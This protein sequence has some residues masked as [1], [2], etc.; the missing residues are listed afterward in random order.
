MARAIAGYGQTLESMAAQATED[1]VVVTLR[2]TRIR[3][4]G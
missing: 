2:P 3:A 1:R 4:Q